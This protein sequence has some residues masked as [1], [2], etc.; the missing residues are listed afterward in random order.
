MSK[1]NK[2][3]FVIGIMGAILSSSLYVYMYSSV[4]SD[5]V[6]VLSLIDKNK[7]DTSILADMERIE[8]NLKSTVSVA[9]NL[10]GLF[11]R[12]EMIVEFIKNIELLMKGSGVS[13]SVDSV[14]EEDSPDLEPQDMEDLKL[15][16]SV[17]GDWNGLLKF[18]GLLE[19]LPYKSGIDSVSF[20]NNKV[21]NKPLD[22][23]A[24][25]ISKKEWQINVKMYVRVIKL[26]KGDTKPKP[27][28]VNPANVN[29]E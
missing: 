24:K 20:V 6:A 12:Q 10:S 13:G 8:K 4:E 22:P 17:H 5:R 9:D 1:K 19:N 25:V 28:T 27:V 21:E 23:K 18:I 29:N 11:V 14:T 2:I 7:L 15:S 16:I 26:K 3:I